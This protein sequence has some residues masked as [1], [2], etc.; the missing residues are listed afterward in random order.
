MC[1]AEVT[2]A[3]ILSKS[4]C[5]C[6]RILI[7]IA[8]VGPFVYEPEA[9]AEVQAGREW[10]GRL[11]TGLSYLELQYN[12][13]FEGLVSFLYVSKPYIIITSLNMLLYLPCRCNQI[14][15]S[16]STPSPSASSS[17]SPPSSYSSP[18]PSSSSSLSSPSP[19]L[20]PPLAS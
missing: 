19:S 16:S 10:C 20:S 17:P 15:S 3:P 8:I 9:T 5:R 13:A 4:I 14:S 12:D 1:E 11:F 18:T 2:I 6:D 7:A